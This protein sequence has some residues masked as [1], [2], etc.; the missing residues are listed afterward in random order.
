VLGPF[1][2]NTNTRRRFYADLEEFSFSNKSPDPGAY[3]WG[4]TI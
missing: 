1:A 4:R 2:D 3:M